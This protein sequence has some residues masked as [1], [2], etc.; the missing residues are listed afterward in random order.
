MQEIK[1]R[2]GTRSYPI[3]VGA[4]ALNG[5]GRWLRKTGVSGDAVVIT[6]PLVRRLHGKK[7]VLALNKAGCSVKMFEVVDSERSKSV[8]VAFSLI[9]KI[10]RY[11]AD[12]KVF[13]VAFG[14]GVIGDLAGFVASSY[15]RGVPFI[16]VPTTLLAQVDSS[17]GG[18][19]GVDLPS[20]KNLVG[21][22]YQPKL[23]LADVKLLSSL[24]E[25]QVRNGLAEV[26][27]YGVI[28]DK[29]LFVFLEDNFLK[30]LRNDSL[31]MA[32]VVM[33]CAKIKADVVSRDE[34]EAKG[35][36]TV[37]NFGH[38]VGH[39]V[40]AA[41]NYRIHH[42]EAVAVGMRVAC[43]ISRRL[44]L[45]SA[46]EAVRLETLL[47]ALGLAQNIKGIAPD[48]ILRTMRFDKKF[49]GKRNRFVLAC[50]IG[51]VIVREGVPPAVIQ[52][53]LRE[54]LA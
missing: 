51:K 46:L 40:E 30:L 32:Q 39:A 29:D 44:K 13:V 37:L 23:V 1:V 11:G 8:K 41:S 47:I 19:V 15:K 16:Q 38:T 4:G 12:K 27:K 20:G 28:A 49:R 7:L 45:M 18:K 36:R 43:E 33:R 17:I 3:V 25:R 9:E 52:R 35:L 24:S 31:A 21:D 50:A 34:R 42:G 53:S 14:G 5:L 6:N 26:V 22:F 48:K 54:F 2:L 10:A